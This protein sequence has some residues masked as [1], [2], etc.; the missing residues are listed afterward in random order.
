[1][2]IA[3]VLFL[4]LFSGEAAG[5]HPIGYSTY[6]GATKDEVR[7]WLVVG[8]ANNYY[9]NTG[10]H[11][12]WPRRHLPVAVDREGNAF[13]AGRTSSTAFPLLN[14]WQEELSGE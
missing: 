14:S 11:L 2:G 1:M 6:L 10:S 9:M 3:P 7:I 13:I 4:S 8:E 5:P 12:D